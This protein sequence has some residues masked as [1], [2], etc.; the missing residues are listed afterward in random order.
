MALSTQITGVRYAGGEYVQANR[1]TGTTV[2]LD[3]LSTSQVTPGTLTGGVY[4]LATSVACHIEFGATPVADNT[5]TLLM[6]GERLIV[7]PDNTKVAVIKL[8]G[9]PDGILRMTL[10]E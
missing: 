8:A 1:L 6:P 9:Q 10:C 2:G 7:V 4:H 3:L 5:H